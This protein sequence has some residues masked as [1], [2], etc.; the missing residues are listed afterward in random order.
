MVLGSLV[1]VLAL[2]SD[3]RPQNDR[4][5]FLLPGDEYDS[6]DLPSNP[7]GTWWVLHLGPSLEFECGWTQALCRRL[8][9]MQCAQDAGSRKKTAAIDI[10]WRSVGQAGTSMGRLNSRSWV[11]AL[12][13]LFQR[14]QVRDRAD[15]RFQ[16]LGESI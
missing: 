6:T 4:V 2:Q 10:D 11:R 13:W 14:L 16:D 15:E 9:N 12:S 3:A 8:K 5:E 1:L 7:G